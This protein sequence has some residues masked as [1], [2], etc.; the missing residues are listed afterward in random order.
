MQIL[1]RF[2]QPTTSKSHRNQVSA[3]SN[4]STFGCSRF[5]K[6]RPAPVPLP[7]STYE[8]HHFLLGIIHRDRSKNREINAT[9]NGKY[10]KS[11]P[12][13]LCEER[14]LPWVVPRCSLPLPSLHCKH[15]LKQPNYNYA[16]PEQNYAETCHRQTLPSLAAVCARSRL[17]EIK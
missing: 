14:S 10:E 7:A 1:F 16:T 9:V 13:L 6:S 3:N 8:I 11:N 5:L 17:V 15:S 2:I 12:H 4:I